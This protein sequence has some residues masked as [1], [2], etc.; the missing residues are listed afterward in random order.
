MGRQETS[1]LTHD[2]VS[3][4][5]DLSGA[6]YRNSAPYFKVPEG[7][8]TDTD[9]ISIAESGS[10]PYFQKLLDSW[11]AFCPYLGDIRSA[12]KA[13]SAMAC[14]IN[15]RKNCWHMLGKSES[16]GGF[17]SQDILAARLLAPALHKILSLEGRAL[18]SDPSDPEFSGTAAR[19]AF[20]RSLLIFLV[21]VQ[22]KFGGTA[23]ELGRH[24]RDF[25]QISQIPYVQWAFVPEFNLWAHTIVAL[26]EKTDERDSHV[27]AIVGIMDT[28]GLSSGWQ[29]MGVVKGIIWIEDLFLD[30]VEET[31]CR[32]IDDFITSRAWNLRFSTEQNNCDAS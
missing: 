31:L 14:Y 19:E 13:T 29:A 11:S 2:H 17:W 23:F 8:I 9:A 7:A 18:P 16:E 21:S 32:E 25:R 22:G 15:E 24:L 30:E 26:H 20:R 28:L 12:L 5:L 6:S 10:R 1:Q 4:R 27:S 3:S